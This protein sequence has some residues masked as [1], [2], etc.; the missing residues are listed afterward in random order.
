MTE[1]LEPR[2]NGA[3]GLSAEEVQQALAEWGPNRLPEAP[4][5]LFALVR[6]QL[7]DA[8][9]YILLAA[10][11]I[12]IA[13][14]FLEG[15][16]LTLGRFLDAFVIGVILV[17][18][19]TLGIA[20]EYQAERA[21]A[22]LD[23]LHAP[24]ARVRRDGTVVLVDAAELVPGDRLLLEAGD[25]LSA[26]AR[27]VHVS[28]LTVDEST[29]TGEA[30]PVVKSLDPA[31]AG[32]PL[33][34]RNS[35]VF[36][37]T[38]VTRGAGEAVVSATG[39][40]TQLG[41]IATLVAETHIPMTPLQQ[42]LQQLGRNLGVVA[43]VLCGLVALV[44]L[45]RELHVLEVLLIATSLAVSAVP[46]GLPAV[47][48][49]CFALGVRRMARQN[50][51]VRR[52]DALETL[53]AVTVVCSDKT[54]TITENRM[55][56]VEHRGDGLDEVALATVFA[57]CSHGDLPDAGDPTELALLAW[58][59]AIGAQRLPID[60]EEVP[61][62]SEAKYMRTRHGGRVFLKGSPE[63]L[64]ALADAVPAWLAEETEAAGRRGLRVL[65]AA[66]AG[67]G[68]LRVVG[69]VGMTDPPRGGVREAVAEARQAGIRTVMI[70]GDDPLTAAAIGAQVGIEGRVRTGRELDE[71]DEQAL[72][73]DVRDT[74]IYARVSPQHK[75]ALC[76]A[77]LANGEVVAMSGDGVNDAPAL[78]RAHV[79]VAMG[80][81]GTDVAR[82]A[83]AVVL[84]DDHF[85][86]IV[87]AVREGRRIHD[88]IRR[89]VLFLLRANFD[90]LLVVLTAVA[91]NLPLPLLPIHILW[92]NLMTD[93]PPALALAN[94]PAVPGV[95]QR[96]PRPAHQHLLAGSMAQLVG[97]ALL[98]FAS[99]MGFF[100]WRY[101][102]GEPIDEIRSSTITLAIAIE[103]FLAMS[104]RS[105][106]PL[107][108]VGL[109]GNPWLLRAIA[110]VAVVH[111]VLLYTPLAGAFHL[112]P[113]TVADWQAI[114]GVFVVSAL[115]LEVL[116]AV[117][118][119]RS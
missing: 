86:T 97:A 57:S 12:S 81:R 29:L 93:G 30:E 82:E 54:G 70:T 10:L 94:E 60:E 91:F 69:W 19:A 92:L 44:G 26:D 114:G 48:T 18:N 56:V 73:E 9:V 62:T 46:E 99:I 66:E 52:L 13:T 101:Q 43:L 109:R 90:E 89:F 117:L 50:A 21:I 88:N 31:E 119:T 111:L 28:H 112:V 6:R 58:A 71:L 2:G 100:L 106:L 40:H 15:G 53:G 98:G 35:E 65:A 75:V 118:P 27:L 115:S 95:M 17:L 22:E 38:L 11:A 105:E 24:R 8:L 3:P 96:P 16:P 74:A 32:A 37:G 20:Q 61:F 76:E 36:A 25:R 68:G 102:A 72:R 34:E 77:L 116:K 108:R 42:R 45:L 103:L 23:R 110:G 33:A 1:P 7:Q 113:L 67:D 85:A 59:E 64:A 87:H 80:L 55:T 51:L 14:P 83:A 4:R 78:K 79:G 84:A 41:Q 107:W 104:A 49:V 47:V 39:V 63:K 5:S